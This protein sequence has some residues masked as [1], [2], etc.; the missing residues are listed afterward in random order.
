MDT[1]KNAVV[2]NLPA[3]TNFQ[4]GCVFLLMVNL[5]SKFED[6]PI[7]DLMHEGHQWVWEKTKSVRRYEVLTAVPR[8]ALRVVNKGTKFSAD[9]IHFYWV[10]FRHTFYTFSLFYLHAYA[11]YLV[12]DS[13]NPPLFLVHAEIKK[14]K[15]SELHTLLHITITCL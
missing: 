1:E 4:E 12:G 5:L 13:G 8:L 6:H 7:R 10:T 3:H 14:K 15:Q 9:H 11:R 2:V